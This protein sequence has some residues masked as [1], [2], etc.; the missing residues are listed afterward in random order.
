MPNYDL[1][2]LFFL[3]RYIIALL[4][5]FSIINLAH[6]QKND[7]T[8]ISIAEIVTIHSTILNEDRKIYIYTPSTVPGFVTP[9]GP[10][11]V[12]YL[13]DAEFQLQMVAGLVDYLS[14]SQGIILPTIIVGIDNNHYDRE[15]DL[16]PTHSDKAD[17]VSKPDTSASAFTKTSGGG[18]KF[19]RFIREE[20]MHYVEQHYNTAPF[21][22]FSGHSLG[23]L[24][25]VYCLFKHPEM[26]NAYIG[27]SPSVWWDNNVLQQIAK[28]KLTVNALKNKYLFFS[29]SSEGGE[30][31]KDI[32]SLHSLLRQK[33]DSSGLLYKYQ[34]YPT[35][36]HGS[37]PAKA[38]YDA[39]KFIFS[40]CYPS[41]KDTTLA[42]I[43]LFYKKFEKHFGY[44]SKPDENMLITIGYNDLDHPKKIDEAVKIFEMAA[45]NY[46]TS[47][48]AF[49]SLGDGYAKKG[50]KAKAIVAY[51]KAIELHS[52]DFNN[53]T[54]T[55]LKTLEDAK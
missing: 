41:Q 15:R 44:A 12:M 21:K 10:F 48:N 8:K 5:C 11:P 28:D 39:L 13:M 6:A 31:Y 26:F 29:I 3:M 17:P 55:K 9:S 43:K 34:Y 51:K 24:M 46:P 22:I 45:E 1:S 52:A 38:E 18:E 2:N 50:N 33:K 30:F 36:T 25:S 16:T 27:I 54:I 37:G 19:L 42:G 7:S 53:D 14:K 20:V 4:V 40:N 49:D 35:E 47:S 23:G 32:Q